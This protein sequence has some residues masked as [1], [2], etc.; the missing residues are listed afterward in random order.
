MT[1]QNCKARLDHIEFLLEEV[2]LRIDRVCDF[3]VMLENA[4]DAKWDMH[5]SFTR[6]EKD[7]EIQ[8]REDPD[9]HR[10]E[11]EEALI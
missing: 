10:R 7:K 11:D 6:D 2:F 9:D 5:M 3:V 4:M 1:D 8:E